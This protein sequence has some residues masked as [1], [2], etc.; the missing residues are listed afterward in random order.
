MLGLWDC[1]RS[2]PLKWLSR[3]V[4]SGLIRV[5]LGLNFIVC[6]TS[7]LSPPT[8]DIISAWRSTI[9][10]RQRNSL[11][12]WGAKIIEAR[13]LPLR[14]RFFARDPFN[15]LIEFVKI[16]GDYLAAGD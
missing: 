6:Q 1:A 13:A 11:I 7:S 16:E 15:N 2:R 14:P 5:P 12:E 9:L 10:T 8:R 3:W 4:G